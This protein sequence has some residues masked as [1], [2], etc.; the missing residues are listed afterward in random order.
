MHDLPKHRPN[1]GVV[2]FNQQGQVWFGHRAGQQ[3]DHAWQFPQGGVDKGED[4][5]AAARWTAGLDARGLQL[6]PA[7]SMTQRPGR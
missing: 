4:V 2:L 1:V 3:G 7:S 6:A 5:E